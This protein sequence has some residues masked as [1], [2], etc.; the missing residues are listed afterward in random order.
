MN[1][2]FALVLAASIISLTAGGLLLA[3]SGEIQ[4]EYEVKT[5]TVETQHADLNETVTLDSLDE[6]RQAAI[7]A[8]W[9]QSDHFLDGASAHVSMDERL[10]LT[11]D[12]R[13]QIVEIEGVP[14]LVG[15]NGPDVWEKATWETLPSSV[16]LAIAIVGFV[17]A[18]FYKE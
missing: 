8:A 13:W 18:P 12:E 9:R 17:F 6:G 3:E 15:I 16:L 4:Y 1:R 5:E 10:N 2:A 11:Q 14:L 7:F